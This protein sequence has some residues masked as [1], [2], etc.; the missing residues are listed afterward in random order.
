MAS[1]K[2]RVN[3]NKSHSQFPGKIRIPFQIKTQF[4][5]GLVAMS[6]L[7]LIYDIRLMKLTIQI[8]KYYM[9]MISDKSFHVLP[10]KT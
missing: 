4:I 5:Y 9:A 2:T 8:A 3:Y 6:I 1:G 10:K 7:L